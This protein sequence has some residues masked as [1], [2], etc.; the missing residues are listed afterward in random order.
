MSRRALA[1]ALCAALLAISFATQ[2]SV[3]TDDDEPRAPTGP[4]P[5]VMLVSPRV[6]EVRF[7]GAPQTQ[8]KELTAYIAVDKGA[9]LDLRDVRD[10]VRALHGSGRFSRVSAWAEE[11]SA[12]QLPAGWASA[13]RVV[14]V[15]QPVLKLVQVSFPGHAA[16]P[17]TIL[18][19][20]ANLAVNAEYQPEAIPRVIEAIRSA[21]FRIGYRD[22]AITPEPNET[23]SGVQLALRIVEGDATRIA[24]ITF[25]GKLGLEHDQLV[26][27]LQLSHGDVLNLSELEEGLRNVRARVRSAGY[28]R[29]RVGEPRIENAG[30][31]QGR[32][33][34]RVTIPLESGPLVHFRVRGNQS[35]PTDL[36]LGKLELSSDEPLDA[37]A[38]SELAGRLRTFYVQNGFFFVKS[39]WR[40]QR[41]QDGSVSIAFALDEGPRVR[42]EKIDFT[43]VEALTE[44][45]LRDRVLLELNDAM[46]WLPPRSSDPASG[47]DMNKL[48]RGGL[49]G[50]IPAGPA[51]LELDAD[52][53]YDPVLYS[54]VR[55]QIADLYKSMGYLSARVD[56]EKLE[57]LDGAPLSGSAPKHAASP[58]RHV[59]VVIPINAGLRTMVSL[60]KIQGGS[61]D[62]PIAEADAAL[63]LRIG[64]PF[65]YLSAEEG[66]AAL[67]QLFTRRGHF[68]CKVEDEEVFHEPADG[69]AKGTSTVEVTYRVQAG[70]LV[71]VAYVEVTGEQRTQESLVRELVGMKPGD[72]LTPDGLDRAQQALLLTGLFFSASLTP[73]NPEEAEAEK[74]V[75]ITLRERPRREVQ[76]SIGLSKA[77]GPRAS[78][79]WTQANLFGRNLTFSALGRANFPYWRFLVPTCGNTLPD[80]QQVSPGSTPYCTQSIQ[81]PNDPLERLVDLGLSMPRLPPFGDLLRGSLDLIHQRAVQYTYNLTKYS[82]QVSVAANHSRPFGASVTYEVGFQQ[83]AKGVQS[84]ADILA[85]TDARIF[86]QPNGNMLFGSLRPAL[87]L[88]LRD[89]PGI[90]RSG[91]YAQVSADY[92]RSLATSSIDVNLLQLQGLVA[93]YV[94]LP[95]RSSVMLHAKV[96]RILLIDPASQVPGDRRFY[97]G[98]AATLRGFNQDALQPQDVRNQLRS[99]VQG[100][101]AIITGLACTNS[102]AALQ[103]GTASTGGDESV[104]LGA[105]LRIPVPII[106][107][108]EVALFYDAGN[109]WVKP[110]DLTCFFRGSSPACASDAGLMVLRDAVG[111][112]VRWGTP[113]GRIAIDIGVNLS[114]DPDLGEPRA[115]LYFNIDT[116]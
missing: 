49:M 35:F 70:P 13:V 23:A 91:F 54:R 111:A 61:D 94:P 66:R 4:V 89:D 9:P 44:D 101:L 8:L 19:Q 95:F 5:Q 83:L 57:P 53:L 112:G 11:V 99:E 64:Q 71:H 17:E 90:P 25:A 26:A 110:V 41:A 86:T 87:T 106:Q 51:R 60:L 21:Y 114:P 43:G 31:A 97:L 42:V 98:G 109:L 113:I 22:V 102:T 48:A 68:Y 40:E 65:S 1:P 84:L 100:C 6:L 33:L 47:A 92:L 32:G 107:G 45:S 75:L 15:L 30:D 3:G 76:A 77:D 69:A 85:G 38:A 16:L 27:A 74:T 79:Q 28:L 105:E 108:L 59:R 55:G 37:Q 78:L 96:G 2:A 24:S 36:L 73:R 12:A 52:T 104:A 115:G 10:T 29:A 46:T 103:A 50:R 116:L 14:F 56:E 58:L 81:L 67:T 62:V 39:N 34:A 93:G 63:S 82:A 18:V 88:D 72:L 20:T 7:E 80:G